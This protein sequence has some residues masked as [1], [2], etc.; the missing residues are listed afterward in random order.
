VKAV[1][2]TVVPVG[3]ITKPVT[4]AVKVITTTV[5]LPSNG[6]AAAELDKNDRKMRL[7]AISAVP[8]AML[9]QIPIRSQAD[10][11]M[12]GKSHT[13]FCTRHRMSWD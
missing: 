4:V 1:T 7:V 6:S 9:E 5:L 13:D 10:T 12:P 11:N 3:G 2:V 8:R